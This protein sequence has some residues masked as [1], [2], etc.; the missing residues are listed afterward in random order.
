MRLRVRVWGYATGPLRIAYD[1]DGSVGLSTAISDS[2]RPCGFHSAAGASPA[3]TGAASADSRSASM[4]A[5]PAAT[6]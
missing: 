6:C 5:R 2:L 3:T 1:A 4:S